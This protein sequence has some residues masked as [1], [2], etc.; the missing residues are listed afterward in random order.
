MKT[1]TDIIDAWPSLS[2]F[3]SDL[4]VPYVNAQVMRYRDSI[5]ADHWSRVEEMAIARGIPGVTVKLM[6]DIKAA[7]SR[8]AKDGKPRPSLEAVA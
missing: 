2:D 7:R 5:S 3:A 4:G 6:A 1:F 8:S